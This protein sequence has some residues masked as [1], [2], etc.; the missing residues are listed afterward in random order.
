VVRLLARSQDFA[1]GDF[2]LEQ[3]RVEELLQCAPEIRLPCSEP[4]R[5]FRAP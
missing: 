1:K 3:G 5:R 4:G 2:A